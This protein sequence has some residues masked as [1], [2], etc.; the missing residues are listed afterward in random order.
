MCFSA[1]LEMK[2]KQ[3]IDVVAAKVDEKAFADLFEQRLTDSSIKVPRGL[4]DNF[5]QPET[6]AAERCYQAIVQY[7][8]EQT[9][10]I[11]QELFM[12]RKRLADAERKLA[13]KHT[14]TAAENQ[15][16]ASKK[17]KW[18]LG[19]LEDLRR[20]KPEPKDDRIFPMMY[21]PV[22]VNIDGERLIR[23]MR[24]HCRQH[25]KPAFYD[26]KFNGLY[27]ARRD[28]L[29]RFWRQQ[30]GQ[31]HGL[32][33][34]KSFYENVAKHDFEQRSLREGEEAENLVLQ[35][36]PQPAIPLLV[37]C[38]YSRWEKD[39]EV[40]LES[41]A[42]I[43][44]EPPAEVAATGHDR[45]VIILNRDSAER[46]LAPDGMEDSALEGLLDDRPILVHE[47]RLAA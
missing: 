7:R 36:S 4:E 13:T 33:V 30:Y 22:I 47:H 34:M 18:A 46:W 37:A 2:L 31:T 24:Y 25:G 21:A 38:L 41:F 29:K 11:E 10:A 15:R 8:A 1:Q 19:K 42:A 40:P 16:I 23:P 3:V 45:C 20:E 44:D 14:K 35:F 17:I 12:Q 32:L 39:G 5:M 9:T 26:R 6:E 27:N 28:N 43:T